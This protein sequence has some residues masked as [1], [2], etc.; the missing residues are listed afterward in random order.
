MY[1]NCVPHDKYLRQLLWRLY[2]M[3]QQ[4][5]QLPTTPVKEQLQA[6]MEGT[7]DQV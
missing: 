3:G 5:E 1:V 6:D 2:V 4:R 7:Q